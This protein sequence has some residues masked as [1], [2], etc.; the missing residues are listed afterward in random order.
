MVQLESDAKLLTGATLGTGK[1]SLRTDD[2]KQIQKLKEKLKG[3]GIYMIP[4]EEPNRSLR[5]RYSD[6]ATTK[7]TDG[8]LEVEE[9]RLS[10][11]QFV[12][13]CIDLFEN[14]DRETHWAKRNEEK[15]SAIGE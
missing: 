6:L 2:P 12:V 3:F 15:G 4:K 1:V 13:C 7:W 14:E 9:H 8:K 5:N 10:V 11:N